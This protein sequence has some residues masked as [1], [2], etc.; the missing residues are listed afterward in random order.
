MKI[1]LSRHIPYVR[2]TYFVDWP[3]DPYPPRLIYF[4]SNYICF[5]VFL[6]FSTPRDSA[7]FWVH[8]FRPS[9]AGP[10]GLEGV[11]RFSLDS[12]NRGAVRPT[13]GWL[14]RRNQSDTR[15]SIFGG[16]CTPWSRL[17]RTSASPSSRDRVAWPL[18]PV[19]FGIVDG[20]VRWTR[21][22]RSLFA[23]IPVITFIS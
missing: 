10:T 20:A 19:T 2:R 21:T 16:R 8:L 6:Y 1:I 17:S 14:P 3:Y 13:V 15:T 11:F 7:Y 5:R 22:H 4:L 9:P 12:L 23:P 18:V